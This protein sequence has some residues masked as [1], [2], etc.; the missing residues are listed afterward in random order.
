MD[1]GTVIGTAVGVAMGL[2][3]PGTIAVLRLLPSV[4]KASDR[5]GSNGSGVLTQDGLRRIIDDRL[6]PVLSRQTEILEHMN[7]TLSDNT[8]ALQIFMR[9]EEQRERLTKERHTD[10]HD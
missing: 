3:V 9:L 10:G 1:V 6:G 5:N 2:A 8:M 4:A 7:Q